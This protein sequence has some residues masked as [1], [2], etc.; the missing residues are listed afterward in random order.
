M[1]NTLFGIVI[2]VVLGGTIMWLV[3]RQ[4]GNPASESRPVEPEKHETGLHL[5]KEEQSVAGIKL[6]N[7]AA[8]ELKPELKAF[9]RVLDSALLATSLTDVEAARSASVAS[10][11]EL[12]RL[13]SLGADASARAL[14]SAE[15][16][17]TRDRSAL[18]AAEVRL[19]GTWGKAL[20]TRPELASL[21]HSLV[22]QDAALIRIDLP[23]GEVPSSSPT[24]CRITSLTEGEVTRNVELI[25]PAASTDPQIQGKA[26]LALLRDHG[27]PPGSAVTAWLTL[28]G[29]ATRGLRLPRSAV[30][31]H[32]GTMF[33]FVQTG[34]ESF[35]R[36][37][38]EIASSGRDWIFVTGGISTDE[39]VV[40]V[41]A[42]QLLSAESKATGGGE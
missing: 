20:V 22:A 5:T 33:V 41:G 3:I 39:H 15:A 2:G 4:P 14:E 1:K 25:G 21:I 37:P 19:I 11:K 42:Q 7:P 10:V 23:A 26:F 28:D 31:Q 6:A 18:D 8:T 34:D 24:G 27:L 17:M 36:K 12:E 29:Q 16:M 13:K 40:I 32:D 30:V 38:V 35:E 9:G